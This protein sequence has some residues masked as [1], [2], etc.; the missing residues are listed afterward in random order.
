MMNFREVLKQKK[1]LFGL[2]I[3]VLVGLGVYYYQYQKNKTFPKDPTQAA[4]VESQNLVEKIGKFMELPNEQPQIATVSD[5]SKLPNQP[6]F[7]RAQNGD[8]VLIYN[9]AQKAILYRPSTNKIIDVAPLTVAQPTAGPV[10]AS[11][12]ASATI[13][14]SISPTSVITPTP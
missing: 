6:F 3:L 14:P 13:T 7:S 10:D 1:L 5:A 11:A 9:I 2:I 8:K 12:T 4:F